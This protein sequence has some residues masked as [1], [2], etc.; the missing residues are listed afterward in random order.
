MTGSANPARARGRLDSGRASPGPRI[1]RTSRQAF[2]TAS[3][4]GRS[5][6]WSEVRPEWG[7]ARN[8]AFIAA[9]RE[10]TRGV[11]LQGR[12]FLHEYDAT[13]DSDG[14]VLTL[15]LNAPMVVASWINL[16]YFASTV[17]NTVFGCGTKTLHNRVGSLGVVL[18]NG[19]D[20]R[21]G[22]ALQS[23]HGAD[24]R[25]FHEP[26]RLQVVIEAHQAKIDDVLN[27]HK[28]VRDLVENGWI[29]LFA[30]DPNGSQTCLRLPDGRWEPFL[31]DDPAPL[32]TPAGAGRSWRG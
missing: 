25:W 10:R 27:A 20:L 12:A 19:G 4:R 30:L 28:A 32:I 8:A 3:L 6:D 9:R 17:D 23:V 29:R 26:L 5:R 13:L 18:G 14:S 2:W 22:L 11:D 1:G 31:N 21:T 24:G 7:L 16:Q 15:I